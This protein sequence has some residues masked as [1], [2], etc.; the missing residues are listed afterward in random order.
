MKKQFVKFYKQEDLKE[1]VVENKEILEEGW[2]TQFSSNW[3][4][5]DVTDKA[6]KLREVI[7]QLSS[8]SSKIRTIQ[9][10]FDVVLQELNDFEKKMGAGGS[11]GVQSEINTNVEKA[12]EVNPVKNFSL[13]TEGLNYFKKLLE[14]GL[15]GDTTKKIAQTNADVTEA[16]RTGSIPVR[17]Q[18]PE[19]TSNTIQSGA[20]AVE[21]IKELNTLKT[22]I[23]ELKPQ[24]TSLE[25]MSRELI[26]ELNQ[27]V[28]FFQDAEPLIT[29]KKS[30]V[31]EGKVKSFEK[32]ITPKLD[33]FKTK[34]QKFYT[35]IGPI[36]EVVKSTIDFSKKIEL[37]KKPELLSTATA[38]KNAIV[39]NLGSILKIGALSLVGITL[40][41]GGVGGVIALMT[42]F[43]TSMTTSLAGISTTITTAGIPGIL[44]IAT[45]AGL[46]GAAAKGI[47]DKNK[48]KTAEPNKE[49]GKVDTSKP[50]QIFGEG[51]IPFEVSNGQSL[52]KEGKI[53]ATFKSDGGKWTFEI[54]GGKPTEITNEDEFELEI[55]GEKF[56][57]LARFAQFS[58]KVNEGWIST[59][60]DFRTPYQKILSESNYKKVGV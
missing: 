48:E 59:Y 34:L 37:S 50:L 57:F 58:V 39:G 28:K 31:F 10:K 51:S 24:L 53:I 45:S 36:D 40:L 52:K 44:G 21:G 3:T 13:K 18:T 6:G 7:S 20:S 15:V 30:D 16:K 35:D 8:E 22:T 55:D 38:I 2:L 33:E 19:T 60:Y 42:W 1:F 29:A 12:K 11:A 43:I 54:P 14:A 49:K 46:G 23:S 47:I 5:K 9:A 27:G 17:N 26:S 41:T 32:N 25:E 56:K 4:G